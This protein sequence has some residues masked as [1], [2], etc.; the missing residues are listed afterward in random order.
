MKSWY[1]IYIEEIELKGD[2][3]DYVNYKIKNKRKMI[4]LIKKYSPNKKIMEAG[5]GT[6]IISTYMSTLGYDVTAVDIDSQIQSLAKK[7]SKEYIKNA[8]PKFVVKDIFELDF[9]DKYFDVIFSN[10]V[11]EHFSDQQ[12]IRGIKLQLQQSN[13]VIIGIPTKFFNNDEALYG[14]ERFLPIKK[15]RDLIKQSGGLIIEESSYDYRSFKEKIIGINKLFRIKPFR[16][17]VI[18]R[19]EI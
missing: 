19:D 1:D 12:I 9:K 10:G 6:G 13:I 5:A 3:V 4:N 11:L 8:K 2:F 15:W 18:K 17:F 16:I 14:D 7:I